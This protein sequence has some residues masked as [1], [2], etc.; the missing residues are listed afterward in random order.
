VV[1]QEVAEE[2]M[3][4]DVELGGESRLVTVLF[5]DIR[6]FTP[7]TEGME[8]QEVIGLLNEC[9]EHLSQAIDA[10]AG[11]VDKFIGDEVMAVFGA[12]AVQEDH[13]R[14]AVAAAVRM[15]VGMATFNAIREAR[16]EE[17]LAIGVG[18]NS[19]VAVAGNM[20]S[21]NRMNYTVVGDMVN[22]ASRLAGQARAGEILISGSTLRLVGP[23]LKAPPLGGRS[24]KGF[25]SEVDVYAVES[26]SDDADPGE[27]SRERATA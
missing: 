8:P 10:E 13:A 4:G 17:P 12:P 14:R 11:V 20:G 5:A 22:L 1:S 2:L 6:G 3:R 15:R 23:G 26:L 16:G 18:I 21:A 27:G 24:L 9:M 25:S 19:G 7:L